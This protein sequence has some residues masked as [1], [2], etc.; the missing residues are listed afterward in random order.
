M[1]ALYSIMRTQTTQRRGRRAAAPLGHS[2]R[3]CRDSAAFGRNPPIRPGRKC[4]FTRCLEQA[5]TG[6]CLRLFQLFA[7]PAPGSRRSWV[8]GPALWVVGTEGRRE[9][10]ETGTMPGD[11]AILWGFVV[12]CG[13]PLSAWGGYFASFSRVG[14][15]ICAFF[16]GLG[17]SGGGWSRGRRSPGR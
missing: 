10:R 6:D 12:S 4:D 13:F 1:C 5:A 2:R 3:F 16:A 15:M 8:L 7:L 17:P 11:G 9:G 14:R